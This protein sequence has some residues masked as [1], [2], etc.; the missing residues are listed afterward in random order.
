MSQPFFFLERAIAEVEKTYLEGSEIFFA[1]KKKMVVMGKN[2]G[3]DKEWST[4][5]RLWGQAYRVSGWMLCIKQEKEYFWFKSLLR[6]SWRY[7][8]D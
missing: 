8:I 3:S 7:W 2:S 4:H 5:G 6:Y 1:K